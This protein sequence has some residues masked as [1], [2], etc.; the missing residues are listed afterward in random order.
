LESERE[1]FLKKVAKINI[2]A[3]LICANSTDISKMDEYSMLLQELKVEIDAAKQKVRIVY[4][5][6]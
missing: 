2:D 4:T 5:F 1:K 3:L 6:L